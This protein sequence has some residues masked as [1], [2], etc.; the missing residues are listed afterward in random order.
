MGIQDEISLLLTFGKCWTFL[1]GGIPTGSTM[2]RQ[3]ESMLSKHLIQTQ[4]ELMLTEILPLRVA[5]LTSALGF[6]Q[7]NSAKKAFV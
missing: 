4:R 2:Q 7:P 1:L 3:K 6:T 5:T